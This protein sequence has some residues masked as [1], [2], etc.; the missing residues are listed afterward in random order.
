MKRTSW[1]H[2]SNKQKT[3]TLLS[4]RKREQSF[5]EKYLAD[6]TFPSEQD[7][8]NSLEGQTT[9]RINISKSTKKIIY[10]KGKSTCEDFDFPHEIDIPCLEDTTKQDV[11]EWIEDFKQLSI[12]VN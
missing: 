6:R 10:T 8:M 3:Q 2:S 9:K 12:N 4:K 7:I 5:V 1:N 11:F